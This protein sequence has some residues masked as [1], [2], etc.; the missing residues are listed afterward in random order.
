MKT[1]SPDENVV[2]LSVR[3]VLD[4]K[5]AMGSA[6]LLVF[7]KDKVVLR[8]APKLETTV[9]Q[10]TLQDGDH[11][12][13]AQKKKTR[14]GDKKQKQKNETKRSGPKNPQSPT[15]E[16]AYLVLGIGEL[17]RAQFGVHSHQGGVGRDVFKVVVFFGLKRLRSHIRAHT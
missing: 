9:S 12:S 16:G 6:D 7:G 11:N 15:R 2:H 10:I 17:N 4:K 14:K 3:V 1:G 13:E 8:R 5:D